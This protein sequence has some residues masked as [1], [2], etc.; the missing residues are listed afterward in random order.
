MSAIIKLDGLDR[1]RLSHMLQQLK[2]HELEALYESLTT[3]RSIC[4]ARSRRMP[5]SK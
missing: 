3:Y 5:L 2:S 1:S 4:N